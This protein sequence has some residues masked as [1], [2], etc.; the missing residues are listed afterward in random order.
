M[1]GVPKLS[2]RI[3]VQHEKIW[4]FG[5]RNRRRQY[6]DRCNSLASGLKVALIENQNLHLPDKEV[7]FPPKCFLPR[8]ILR[9]ILIYL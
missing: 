1:R 7:V 3:E 9:L 6:R 8:L 4:I 5:H 2:Y